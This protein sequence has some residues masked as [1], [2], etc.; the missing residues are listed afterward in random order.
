MLRS[1]GRRS[2]RR[3][4]GINH[5]TF[6]TEIRHPDTGED[7]YPRLRRLWPTAVLRLPAGGD[8]GGP[9]S[10]PRCHGSTSR[11]EQIYAPL[12][13]PHVPRVRAPA[14]LG[15]QPHRRVRALR[16]GGRRLA[17]DPRLLPPG[18]HGPGRATGDPL[19]QRARPW[20]RCTGP[21]APPK[22]RS[23][24][25]GRCAPARPAHLNAVNVPNRGYVP[26]LPEGAIVEVP[27]T[28]GTG[29]PRARGG[30]ADR[31]APGRVHA[32][33]DRDP[34]PGGEVGA[35]R[36]P[37]TGFRCPVHGPAVAARPRRRAGGCSTSWPPSRPTRFPFSRAS[38]MHAVDVAVVGG[39]LVGASVAYELACAGVSVALIDA[40]HRGRASD[41]GAGIVS[42]ETF[43]EPDEEWFAFGADRGAAPAGAR[44][45]PRR[46]RRRRGARGL[47][48]LRVV[49]AGAGRARGPVVRGGPA[50]S[51]RPRSPDHR[52]H[53][54]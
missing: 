48:R 50:S 38:R 18:P 3:P 15:R 30:T 13:D 31:R 51:D 42:P 43:Q 26:N 39:G 37:R 11:V 28:V 6:F 2:R 8:D 36:G 27:A 19:R 46:R 54:R 53:R 33:P 10:W 4:S 14:V 45:S 41:A 20:S 47:R 35:H 22:R 44:R 9:S 12:V 7:L 24:S 25:S 40:S 34:G 17:P 23:R 1:Q 49:G 29:W 52:D 32:G 5:F 16:Q 21:A